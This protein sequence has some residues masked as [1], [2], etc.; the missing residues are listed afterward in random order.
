M[1]NFNLVL[2]FLFT[3]QFSLYYSNEFLFLA[4]NHN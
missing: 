1:P 3:N 2:C 4:E